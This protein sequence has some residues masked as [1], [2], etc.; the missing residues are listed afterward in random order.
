M[1]ATPLPMRTAWPQAWPRRRLL[2]ALAAPWLPA[3]AG[4]R[5]PDT[6]A[7][8]V[9]A[10]PWLGY[11]LM[12]LAQL[13]R[14]VD[15][16]QVRLVE[17]PN[18]TASLR[19]LASGTL[20]GAA[21]TLDEV[22]SARARGLDLQVV[23]VIDESRGADVLLG[24]PSVDRLSALKGRRIGFEQSACGALML[25]AALQRA[26]LGPDDVKLVALDFNQ[27]AAA[28]REGKVDALVTFEPMR[29]L[30]MQ[31]GARPLFSSAQAPGLIVDVLAMR[32]G[33]LVEHGAAVGALVAGL[34]RARGDW[35]RDAAAQAPLMAPRLRL[36]AAEVISAF[37]LI[38]LPDLASNRAWL[39]AGDSPLQQSALRLVQ[40][41]RRAGLL[42]GTLD[43]LRS[44]PA[45]GTDRYL[46][47]A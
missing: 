37:Q 43:P 22:L 7:V 32:A 8:R 30:L 39:A 27:H 46:A 44:T 24:G 41:M 11:E 47:H 29:S 14:H 1:P 18:A 6:P 34:L 12:F 5:A 45:L 13:R 3:L 20:E 31:Q 33:A 38:H 17:A 15:A 35:L 10:N 42:P 26:G 4:C 9:G 25:D 40:V 28:F 19:A 36:S 23:A 2:G 16:D 21:L